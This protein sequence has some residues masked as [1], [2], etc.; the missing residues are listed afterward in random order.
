[1]KKYLRGH[2]KQYF[3]LSVIAMYSTLHKLCTLDSNYQYHKLAYSLVPHKTAPPLK[4][5]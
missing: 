4:T 5:A 1:M 3:S 2:T